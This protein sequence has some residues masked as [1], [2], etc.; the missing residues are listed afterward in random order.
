MNNVIDGNFRALSAGL[1][2]GTQPPDNGGMDARV[3]KLEDFALATRDRLA[4]I[5]STMATGADVGDL[6][7]EMH[8]EFTTQTWRIIGA[9]LTFGGA[10]SAA[11]YFIARN[12]R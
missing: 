7:G 11:V 10:L 12:V 8:K 5:E 2:G 3:T 4:R 9:M 6:R 1:H